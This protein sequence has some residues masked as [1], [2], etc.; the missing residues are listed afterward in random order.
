MDID[1]DKPITRTFTKHK[2]YCSFRDNVE[3]SNFADMQ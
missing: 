1:L 2:D 3:G